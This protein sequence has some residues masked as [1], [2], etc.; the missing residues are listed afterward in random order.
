MK[1]SSESAY[2]NE[3]ITPSLFFT[4]IFLIFTGILL[5]VAL[6][7]EQKDLAVFSLLLLLLYAGLKLW[8]ILSIRG[9]KCLYLV[10]RER[11][12]PDETVHLKIR[13][14]NNK[15]LP[16]FIKI[17]VLIEPFLQADGSNVTINE[18]GGLLWYQGT[19]F[20]RKII[21]QKRGI[22]QIG[23]SSLTTGDLFGIFPREKKEDQR[24]DVIVYP[25]MVPIKPFPL[26]KRIIFGKSGTA[27]PVRD[28]AYILGTRDYQHFRPARFIHWKASAR[29][30]RL[31]EKI[32]EPAEQDKVM[33]VLD[34]DQFHENG[35]Y[36]EFERAIEVI[37]TLAAALESQNYATGFITNCVQQGEGGYR[38]SVLKNSGH[39]PRFLETL[40]KIR[41]KPSEKMADLLNSAENLPGDATCV[42][43]AYHY[44]AGKTYFKQRQIPTV[45]IICKSPP[46]EISQG[47]DSDVQSGV[48]YL[49]DIFIAA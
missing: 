27:S 11:L 40:A 33:L 8:S 46:S 44:T 38:P 39:L 30:N 16:V 47:S 24:L 19:T 43:F 6:L 49:K 4:P 32:F 37:A 42:Y 31:Q 35:A 12:F 14:E 13:I 21:A 15:L 41:I 17:R 23:S 1:S 2:L 22:Y 28:P 36:D 10:D 34:V 3:T 20:H 9:I 26:L 25:R 48:Y 29:H 5:F 7:Y 45:Y 18:E